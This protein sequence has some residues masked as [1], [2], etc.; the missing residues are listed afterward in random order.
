M[1]EDTE[2]MKK[3]RGLSQSEM[4]PCWKKVLDKDKVEES[5]RG[6]FKGRGDPLAWRKV[7]ENN[8]YKIRKWREDCW[9]RIFLLV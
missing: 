6:A 1:E 5:K 7:R 8:K 9:A 2:E 4:D 3:R